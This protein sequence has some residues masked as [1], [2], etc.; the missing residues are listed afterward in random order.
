VTVSL[1]LRP[2]D[3]SVALADPSTMKGPKQSAAF[4]VFRVLRFFEAAHES[5]SER[6]SMQQILAG[7][8][9]RFEVADVL[10]FLHLGRATG[11]LVFERP[12]QETKLFF[13]EGRP[14]FATST[15]EDLRFGSILVR[16]GK[17][18]SSELEKALAR[19]MGRRLRVGQILME[20]NVLTTAE[21]TE[22]LKLQV[23][24]VIFDTFEWREG[25]FTF[26]DRVPAPA[27]AV[28][29]EMDL[30][31]LIMEGVRRLDE[32]AHLAQIFNDPE[33]I[34]ELTTNPERVKRTATFTPEEWQVFLLVDGQRSVAE[35]RGL[36]A[37]L[38]EQTVLEILRRLLAANFV[39]L[40]QPKAAVPEQEA[41]AINIE[42]GLAA[43]TTRARP[44]GDTR[45]VVHP[46][47]VT[48]PESGEMELGRRLVLRKD[49]DEV[50]VPL[51]RDT[52]LVGRHRQNDVVIGDPKVSS[53]HAR[54][55]RAGA[56]FVVIDLKSRNGT[57]VNKQRIERCVLRPGD[58]VR[59]GATRIA[60]VVD[61]K[62]VVS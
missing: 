29:L 6:S 47:A 28:P 56:E 22:F 9:S 51:T 59:I 50:S 36:V 33:M 1:E 7:D 11:V 57:F 21:L 40:V 12:D 10:M 62:R 35:I 13:S 48:L 43:E 30:Q 55:E 54:F 42:A 16:T 60:Y 5:E 14:I 61:E 49:Q 31:N 53:F 18:S 27:T 34:V 2:F 58:V 23:S 39:T 25:S 41:P 52:I 17:L 45:K 32:R 38:D 46:R 24:D 44:R 26:F 4:R 3:I 20:E 37:G 8:I 15:R 19:G